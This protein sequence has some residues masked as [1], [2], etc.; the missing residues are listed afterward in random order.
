MGSPGAGRMPVISREQTP[1]VRGSNAG[2]RH[3][4]NK[5]K[6]GSRKWWEKGLGKS[7]NIYAT[8]KLS[9]RRPTQSLS[10]RIKG[11]RDTRSERELQVYSFVHLS[12]KL[13]R[14]NHWDAKTMGNKN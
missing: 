6:R 3:G 2:P 9:L 4:E 12:P 11:M 10:K 1:D 14:S 13:Q 5:G 8:S 7:G